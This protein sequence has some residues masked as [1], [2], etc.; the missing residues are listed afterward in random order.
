MMPDYFSHRGGEA[1]MLRAE[2]VRNR[3]VAR[4][5]K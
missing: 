4:R 5:E 1:F 2:Q 3:S